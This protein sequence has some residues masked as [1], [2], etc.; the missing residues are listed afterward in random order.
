MPK[1]LTTHAPLWSWR[2]FILLFFFTLLA[3][4]FWKFGFQFNQLPEGADPWQIAKNFFSAALSPAIEDQNPSLPEGADPFISRLWDNLLN[5]LRYAFI[6]MSMALPLG[7]ILGFFASKSWW[8][9]LSGK[10]RWLLFLPAIC[11][12]V[13]RIFVT[14]IRSI[15]ELI[16]ILFFGACIGDSPLA[17]CFAIALPFAGTLAKV[18]SEMLDEQND[19]ASNLLKS[20][21]AS[22]WQSFIA[23]RFPQALPDILSYTMYRL[24]CAIRASAVLGFVGMETIGLSIKQ[25][26]T[27]N[28]YN[29]VWTELYLLIIVVIFFDLLSSF[30]RRRLHTA[31]VGKDTADNTSISS[32]KRKR[33]RWVSLQFVWIAL[34]AVTILSWTRGDPLNPKNPFQPKSTAERTA[35]FFNDIT[36]APVRE[37]GDWADALPWASELWST[38]GQEA[39]F[40]TLAIATTALL[41]AA[42]FAYIIIP[43]ASRNIATARP[44]GIKT[45]RQSIITIWFWKGIGFCTRALFLISRSVPEYILAYLLFALLGAHAWPL[46]LAIAI[47][48]FG[49]LGRL[50]AEIAENSDELA[51]KHHYLKGA[52]RLQTF[53]CGVLPTSQNRQLLFIFYRWETCVREATVLGM[54]S[55]PSLGYLISLAKNQSLQYDKMLFYVLLGTTVIVISDILSIFLR[56]KLKHAN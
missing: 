23:A 12:S 3:L 56:A 34:I 14:F 19:E 7:L 13:V 10:N 21:G 55:I 42:C 45:G 32:L 28:Y 20:S 48:N 33:P 51:A 52:S 18:F 49:I 43:W 41:L 54:V 44:F 11:Y 31:P 16:W 8:P 27:N 15:H 46:I 1:R 35:D 17:A 26:F 36:P 24:E 39:L 30:I 5:T 40:G 50:W 29:E 53:T 2:R 6:A 9:Q 38:K 22:G 37:S 47:H 25:S 4:G